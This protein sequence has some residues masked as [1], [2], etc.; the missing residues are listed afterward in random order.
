MALGVQP[1]PEL[2]ELPRCLDGEQ[3]TEAAK[4]CR[5]RC[6]RPVHAAACQRWLSS[7]KQWLDPKLTGGGS[8]ELR[9]S[10]HGLKEIILLAILAA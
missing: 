8:G 1:S 9:P 5:R 2:P 3:V 4:V 6:E 10:H 7:T